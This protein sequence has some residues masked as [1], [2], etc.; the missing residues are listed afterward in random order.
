M[1]QNLGL[2]LWGVFYIK[3]KNLEKIASTYGVKHSQNTKPSRLYSMILF[4]PTNSFK[5]QATYVS[6]TYFN[7]SDKLLLLHY[8]TTYNF[9]W[10]NKVLK[11][12]T[13]TNPGYKTTSLLIRCFVSR[14]SRVWSLLP[15]DAFLLLLLFSQCPVLQNSYLRTPNNII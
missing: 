13:S 8:L 9:P 15:A 7:V 10:R 11:Q 5:P 2:V 3:N 14:R 1:R 6:S 4:S 12:F